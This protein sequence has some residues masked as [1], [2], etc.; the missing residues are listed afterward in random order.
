MKIDYSKPRLINNYDIYLEVIKEF[1]KKKELL[2]ATYGLTINDKLKEILDNTKN[3]K[4]IVGLYD[5]YCAP[6][7]SHCEIII[8]EN[9]SKLLEYQKQYGLNKIVGVNFLHKKIA[10]F[11]DHVMIGGF[12]LTNSNFIDNAIH[13]K[14]K[15]LWT[16]A[17]RLFLNQFE[18]LETIKLEEYINTNVPFGKHKGKDYQIL[19]DDTD[20]CLYMKEYSGEK[21]DS[22]NL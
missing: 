17:R 9:K 4:I 11:S 18:T 12:N 16:D 6:G 15:E 20:Y 14:N 1:S 22:K 2:L 21:K 5:R 7:C 19:W 3:F 10:L 8:R 13:I